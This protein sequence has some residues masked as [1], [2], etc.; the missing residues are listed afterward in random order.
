MTE[1][2]SHEEIEAKKRT[3]DENY[4]KVLY[5]I[6]DAAV[7]SGRRIEDIRL[8]AAT[9]TVDVSVINHAIESGIK[10]IGENRVQEYLSKKDELLP[11]EF[12]FIGRLQT[13][14]VKYLIG[15]AVMIQS[16]DTIKLAQ[17]IGRLSVKNNTN[18]D[19]LL[20]VNIGKEESKAGFMPEE[21]MEKSHE[22]SEIEG[23]RLRGIMAI[24]P[25]CEDGGEKN[26]EY[27]RKIHKL[28]VDMQAQKLDN[29]IIDTMS[30]GM[31]DDYAEAIL[32]G[33]NMVRIGSALFGKRI[34][35]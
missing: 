30:V 19:I 20:E 23:I 7:K 21:I 28:F 14:K 18:T 25:V 22:I 6:G 4:K 33:S 8:L 34:Y 9:K 26:R 11:C 12:H 17:E 3:F 1:K 31:S 2:L 5:N 24:P 16:V 32:E 13:N 15:N 29:S 27:F 10:L 35:F